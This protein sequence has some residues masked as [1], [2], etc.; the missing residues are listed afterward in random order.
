MEAS[1]SSCAQLGLYGVEKVFDT[2]RLSKEAFLGNFWKALSKFLKIFDVI[3]SEEA[4]LE[5]AIYLCQ[6]LVELKAI[7][8]RHPHI[9]NND[10]VSAWPKSGQ[11]SLWISLRFN[12]TAREFQA[13]FYYLSEVGFVINQ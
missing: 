6:S 2:N 9:Q 12:D 10:V 3:C 4:D 11:N 8:T 5:L 13:S 1:C 7:H